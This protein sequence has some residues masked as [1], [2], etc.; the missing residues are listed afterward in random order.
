VPDHREALSAK[1]ASRPQRRVFVLG[2]L[3]AVFMLGLGLRLCQ[4]DADSLW[5]D[6]I[7]AVTTS[8]RHI[9][10]IVHFQMTDR[11]GIGHPPLLYIVTHFF[12]A[13][14]GHNEF[15]ARLPAAL[16][17]S[18][19]ILVAYKVGETLWTRREGLVGAL[20]LAASAYHIRYSQ[21]AR[22]YSLMVFLA[23]LSLVFLLKAL[24]RNQK[25]LWIGF[26]LCTSLS[27]YNHM[28][29]AFFL[30]AEAS[31]GAAVIAEKLLR[32]RRQKHGGAGAAYDSS[33]TS[34]PRRQGLALFASISL[35]ILSY[36]PWIP[37]LQAQLLKKLQSGAAAAPTVRV[38]LS[39][40]FLPD[41]LEAFSSARG[42]TLL[43]WVGVC[44]LGLSTSGVKRFLLIALWISVPF[45]VLCVV[46]VSH[47][48][49]PR[50]VLFI[51]PVY[52]L[53]TARGIT[54][55]TDLLQNGLRNAS[56]QRSLLAVG[57]TAAALAFGV[58]NLAPV[59][60]YYVWQKEDWRGAAAY[61]SERL[62]KGDVVI[63]D[64]EEYRGGG[65]A[66]RT[67][68]GLR[69]YLAPYGQ[70]A[71]VMPARRGLFDEMSE[72]VTPSSG[73][74]G[75]LWHRRD[76]VN[77]EQV[78][79]AIEIV[80]FSRVSLLRLLSPSGDLVK[81]A[82]SVLKTLLLLQPK[83]EGRFDVHLALAEIYLRT[84]RLEQAE[85]ELDM[86]A[87]VAPDSPEASRDLGQVRAGFDKIYAALGDV[88]CTLWRNLG[89]NVAFLG[90]ALKPDALRGG[91]AVTI[92]MWW[93]ALAEMDADY[94]VF[95]HAVDRHNRIWAQEDKLLEHD[96]APTSSWAAGEVVNGQYELELPRDTP[97]GEY[98]VKMGMYKWETGER[99]PAWDE[100]R[101]READS[102]VSLRRIT[103]CGSDVSVR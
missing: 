99:L 69:Y 33:R 50:H 17:G 73:V 41:L 95:I 3:L 29:A 11:Y 40:T 56:H 22:H 93:Q 16:F 9:R 45:S 24:Q 84:G 1:L 90:Y 36:I 83:V 81:D 48:V 28:F 43:L 78:P 94:T 76:L 70:D 55:L 25:G 101:V 58:L 35:I 98:S 44:L 89:S 64:G 19:S 37:V 80:T 87:K 79:E 2:V 68:R 42:A 38:G 47:F 46:Q 21:E 65:G 97:P 51:L 31:F 53:A 91:E 34:P 14:L 27:L 7:K 23:L 15:I 100:H 13:Y 26:V 57:S 67:L 72:V 20:L 62:A 71:A 39:F 63:A 60:D 59:R 103:V 52:L 82:V 49:D 18:L 6:E 54:S 8:E 74:W 86:A 88:E 85:L 75:V 10:S 12:L 4:L 102:T 77:V 32:F 66:G 30:V 96:G 5:N 92:T 61:L